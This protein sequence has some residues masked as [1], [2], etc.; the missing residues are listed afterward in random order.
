MR[1]YAADLTADLHDIRGHK[2]SHAHL[3]DPANYAHSHRLKA[4]L[5]EA[6]SH[7]TLYPSVRADGRGCAAALRPRRLGHCRQ[8]RQRADV[9]AGD[10]PST[11]QDSKTTRG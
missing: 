9:L 11:R 8:E 7:C 5:R 2:D 6:G 3:Y 1:V 10:T 4:A